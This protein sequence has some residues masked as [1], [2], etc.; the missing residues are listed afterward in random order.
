MHISPTVSIVIPVYNESGNLEEL[1]K[2][3]LSL[4][5]QLGCAYEII[6][7]DDGSNDESADIIQNASQRNFGR[8]IGVFLNRNGMDLRP[9][10]LSPTCHMMANGKEC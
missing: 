5:P 8:I 3:C 7:V 6:L 10:P 4:G 2:R 9:V 1:I